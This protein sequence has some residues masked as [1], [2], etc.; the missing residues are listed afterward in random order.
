MVTYK[1]CI[2]CKKSREAY[3]QEFRNDT[4]P[5]N[6]EQRWRPQW[7]GGEKVKVEKGATASNNLT[8]AFV[9][10]RRISRLKITDEGEQVEY[11]AKDGKPAVTKVVVGVTYDGQTSNDPQKWS[12][13]NKSL[14]SLIDVFGDETRSWI[15]KDVE[16]ALDGSGDYKHI[17]VDVLRT[18]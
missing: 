13:N 17:T 3:E 6:S 4:Q 12:L 9:T 11:P 10:D 8:V 1:I 14:N 7:H 5:R 15:G 16:I 2:P 18:K